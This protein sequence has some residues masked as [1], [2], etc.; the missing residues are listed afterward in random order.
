MRYPGLALSVLTIALLQGCGERDLSPE[1]K[2][3]VATLEA[4]L[5]NTKSEVDAS[6]KAASAYAGGLIKSLMEVRLEILK[7]NQALLE[8]RILAVRSGGGTKI[9]TIATK[10][11]EQLAAQ[12]ATEVAQ[13]K[14][15]IQAAQAEAARYSGGLVQAMK[16][17]TVA[18]QEQSLA[19][20]EQRYL[21]AKYG[22]YGGFSA[23]A[24]D[25]SPQPAPAPA[26]KESSSVVPDKLPAGNGPFGL[27]QG[28]SVD[29]IEKMAGESLRVSDDSENLYVLGSPPKPNNSFD[30]YYLVVS[31]TV[32]LCAVRAIGKPISTNGYGSQLISRYDEM[33]SALS[34]VYGK[35]QSQEYLGEGSIWK[36]PSDW[37]AGL[38][39]QE[40]AHWS[41][42]EGKQ[43]SPLKN[44]LS[45]VAVGAIALGHDSGYVRVEYEFSNY[46]ACTEEI[47]KKS[48][49]SL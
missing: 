38:Y 7:T 31:P 40:R 23:P 41:K 3:Y 21:V 37:M 33:K 32:G 16:L 25:Q 12:L 48:Q 5:A 6:S 44:S 4:E 39:K 43:S 11:D 28:L 46:G 20:L 10:P 29:L 13:L 18:T 22:L 14:A 19:M 26:H 17:A 15:S 42:W 24:R 9:G 47:R 35:P 2:A 45:V 34:G 27:E 36:E 8:Q 1:Q 30:T 49:S